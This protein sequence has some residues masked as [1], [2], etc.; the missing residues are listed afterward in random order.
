MLKQVKGV[1][2]CR[3]TILTRVFWIGNK[4]KVIFDQK[5]S[6]DKD[7]IDPKEEFLGR[8]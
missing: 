7:V 6:R 4:V 2:E 3:F 1:Q 5:I 8:S